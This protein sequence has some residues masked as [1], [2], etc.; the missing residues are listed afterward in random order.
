ML[1]ISL[2]PRQ[3]RLSVIFQSNVIQLFSVI[4]QTL[5]EI[6][7][8]CLLSI[9]YLLKVAPSN[10]KFQ[11]QNSRKCATADDREGIQVYCYRLDFH[12]V[13]S[14]FVLGF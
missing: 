7:Q 12:H 1:L 10:N 9:Y 3:Y 11:F 8:A 13:T 4:V 6:P 2:T 5:H 14:T